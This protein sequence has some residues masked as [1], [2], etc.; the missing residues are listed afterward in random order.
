MPWPS[1]LASLALATKWAC[2]QARKQASQVLLTLPAIP[3]KVVSFQFPS[4]P[5]KKIQV[6]Q[7]WKKDDSGDSYLVTKV[8]NE[9]LATFAVLRKA[10]SET[11]APLRVKVRHAGASPTLP[12]FRFAQESDEF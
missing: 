8:Y 12:G 1:K 7:V 11:D 5:I 6:G 10:G 9:A 3:S 2:G 4:M